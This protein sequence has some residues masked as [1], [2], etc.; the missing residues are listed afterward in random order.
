MYRIAEQFLSWR[1]LHQPAAV[2]YADTVT[3][4]AHHCQVMGDKQT[5]QAAFL[6]QLFKKVHNLCL[7]GNIE[8]SD[9]LVGDDQLWI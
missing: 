7:N 3:D 6:L 2:H 5:G 1:Q 4:I 9:G 8:R